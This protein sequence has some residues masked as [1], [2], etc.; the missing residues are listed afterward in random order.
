[1][2]SFKRS[3][4]KLFGKAHG[5]LYRASGSRLFA[6]LGQVP[7]LLL[8]AVGRTSGKPRTVPLLYVET[9]DGYA[10]VASFGG[11]PQHPAWYLNLQKTPAAR[12]QIEDRV[13]PV[14]ASTATPEEKKSLWP[15]FTEIYPDYDN[16]ESETER[17]IP[18]V[19]LRV[20]TQTRPY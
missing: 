11:A 2:S 4:I 8:T 9:D 14:T 13:I 17:D 20:I 15:R 18:V 16:Y 7:T 10:I 6:N 1:M 12:V 3:M 5:A 19:L